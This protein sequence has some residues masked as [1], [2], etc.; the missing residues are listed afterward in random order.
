M[1]HFGSHMN[2]VIRM[3]HG[4]SVQGFFSNK[5]WRMFIQTGIAA[6]LKSFPQES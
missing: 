2:E 6:W 3:M 5:N 4:S 1:G